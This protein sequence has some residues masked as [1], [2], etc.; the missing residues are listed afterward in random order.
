MQI[1][2]IHY[3]RRMNDNIVFEI[4]DLIVLVVSY[5]RDFSYFLQHLGHLCY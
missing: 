3:H 1:E 5:I 4:L 2:F